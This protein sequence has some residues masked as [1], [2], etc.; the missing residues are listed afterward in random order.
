MPSAG[1]CCKWQS[2]GCHQPKGGLGGLE[3]GPE[4]PC[5][6]RVRKTSEARK[7]ASSVRKELGE[8]TVSGLK[9][10]LNYSKGLESNSLTQ[11]SWV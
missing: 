10:T 9:T 3:E 6:F 5:G 4:R 8:V 2:G 1:N 11:R 7:G